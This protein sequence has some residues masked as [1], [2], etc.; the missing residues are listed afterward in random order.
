MVKA[1]KMKQEQ[2]WQK[3]QNEM[4]GMNHNPDNKLNQ[5]FGERPVSFSNQ[6]RQPPSQ[7]HSGV[8]SV[9]QQDQQDIYSQ[10]F[11]TKHASNLAAPY[12]HLAG[13]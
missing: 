11:E 3:G 9:P 2:E 13:S 10:V 1:E 8:R 6:Q 7:I 4:A 12:Y 5:Y